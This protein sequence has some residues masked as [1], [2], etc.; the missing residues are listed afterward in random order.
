MDQQSAVTVEDAEKSFAQSVV[1]TAGN[2]I[3]AGDPV[4]YRVPPG[5]HKSTDANVRFFAQEALERIDEM[6]SYE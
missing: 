6:R 3:I 5:Y 1:V 4:V 2:D